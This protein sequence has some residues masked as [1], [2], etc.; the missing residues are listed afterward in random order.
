MQKLEGNKMSNRKAKIYAPEFKES[1][2]KLALE[3]KDTIAQTARE[4]GVNVNTLHTWIHKYS[5]VKAANV[6][7]D[8]SKIY[9][10]LKKLKKENYQLT[11]ERDI[12]K[13]AAAYFAKES[14]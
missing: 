1:S 6:S 13:K 9:Q 10:E 14:L 4:L 7:E 5:G 11:Q 2:A 3:S 12:L 8:E